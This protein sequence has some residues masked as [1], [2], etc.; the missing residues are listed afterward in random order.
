[1]LKYKLSF[2]DQLIKIL[3]KDDK[4]KLQP[5]LPRLTLLNA[6]KYFVCIHLDYGDVIYDQAHNYPFKITWNLISIMQ[7]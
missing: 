6:N 2:K 7:C 4:S 1:M 3:A 5:V